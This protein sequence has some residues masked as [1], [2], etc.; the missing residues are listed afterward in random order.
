MGVDTACIQDASG[1]VGNEVAIREGTFRRNMS[2]GNRP[3]L[4]ADGVHGHLL[5]SLLRG[6]VGAEFCLGDE[7]AADLRL[8][9]VFRQ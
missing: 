9:P 4:A 3:V 6:Q 5:Q 8:T 2:F 1:L 7:D